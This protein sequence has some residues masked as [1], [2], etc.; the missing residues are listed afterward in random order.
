M[1]KSNH[2][3]SEK[4]RT[5][6]EAISPSNMYTTNGYIEHTNVIQSGEIVFCDSSSSMA[7]FNTSLFVL[8]KTT[9]YSRL[10]LAV[11]MTSDETE[12]TVSWA[13]QNVKEVIP[14]YAFYGNGPLL[15]P[16]VFMIDDSLV[17]KSA[18]SKS[19][20]IAKIFL[21]TFHFL[22]RRWTW[23]HNGRKKNTEGRSDRVTE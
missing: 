4:V 6:C 21:C 7:M 17:E 5:L 9:A 20:R 1:N 19:W 14:S 10:T 11:V 16:A 15:G 18:L 12:A 3:Q 23:L 22:Q 13:M 8:S 2:Q